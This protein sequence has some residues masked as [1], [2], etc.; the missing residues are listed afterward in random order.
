MANDNKN[1]QADENKKNNSA[2]E[3]KKDKKK[4]T[5]LV[6]VKFAKS[7][8]PYVKG[9]VAGLD[10]EEAEKLIKGKFCEKA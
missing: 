6:R 2:E 10:P 5:K 8:T 9:D 7:Y 3:E 4:K 1:N